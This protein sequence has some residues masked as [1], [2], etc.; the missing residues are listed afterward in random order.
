MTIYNTSDVAA[1]LRAAYT[2]H[3]SQMA[4][5]EPSPERELFFAG[6]LANLVALAQSFGLVA[7]ECGGVLELEERKAIER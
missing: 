3:V 7:R 2:A 4:I 6:V 5:E 1:R